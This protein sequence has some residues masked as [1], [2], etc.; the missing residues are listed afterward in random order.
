MTSFAKFET[1]IGLEVHCQL[2]TASK[3]FCGCTTVFGS[4]ANQNTCSV[5]LGLP[6][7]LP[8]LNGEAVKKA[9]I[10]AEAVQG[11]VAN[12]SVFDRKQYF[13]QDL[14]KG[15]QI[16][17]F[18]KPYCE[19]GH[20]TLSSGKTIRLKRIHMEEDAGKSVHRPQGTLI[21]LN[22]AGIPLVEIVSEPDLSSPLEA[23]EYLKKL[24]RIVV[25]LGISDGNMEEGSFRC[26]ANVSL[27]LKSSS[28]LGTRTEIKN[29]NSFKFLEK[30]ILFEIDRQQE[31]LLSGGQVRQ[32]TRLFDPTTGKT[33]AMR[34]KEDSDDYRYFPD[35]DLPKL[36]ISEALKGTILRDLPELPEAKLKR[37][38]DELGLSEGDGE[39]LIAD[40]HLSRYFEVL[41]TELKGVEGMAPKTIAHWVTGEFLAAKGAKGWSLGN[42]QLTPKHLAGLLRLLANQTISGKLAKVVF[43]KMVETLESADTIVKNEGLVQITDLKQVNQIVIQVIDAHPEQLREYLSGKDKLLAFFVG[44]VMRQSQGKLNPSLVQEAIKELLYKRRG[45]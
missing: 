39:T 16:S 1:V 26:D 23:V 17:Q 21:D 8:V 18:E 45:N 19:G 4:Q 29:L 25:H 5:C 34:D 28:K 31:I 44:Q 15:Y 6:G 38:L 12:V 37:Y 20:L 9:V 43:H 30:A 7:A 42:P 2:S 14:P 40:P 24:H 3:L 27:K 13:Y 33:E 11:S 10:L 35:P 41:L 36:V 22:R 32:Q